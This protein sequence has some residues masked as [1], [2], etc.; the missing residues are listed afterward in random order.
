MARTTISLAANSLVNSE[1]IATAAAL[2]AGNTG[3]AG[4]AVTAST[5]DERFGLL[6]TNTGS[7]TGSV[8]LKASDTM[9]A[10]GIGDLAVVVGG[11]VTKLIGPVDGMRFR[12]SNG[13]FNLDSGITGTVIAVEV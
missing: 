7:A 9:Q 1:S 6:V 8:W 13:D 11:S 3:T 4:Y 12:Q 2:T 10:S 5:R